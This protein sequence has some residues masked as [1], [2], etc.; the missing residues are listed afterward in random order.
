[1][2]V[3]PSNLVQG[4]AILWFAGFGTA[5]PA[6]SA[7]GSAPGGS[8]ADVGGTQG[9]V[10]WEVDDTY[11]DQ[12]V[13]QVAMPVGARFT[14]RAVTVTAK[15]AEATLSNMALALNSQVT[16]ASGSGYATLEPIE[17][18][19]A[20]QP[21]FTALIVD[22]WAPTLSSGG[23]ARRRLIVRKALSQPK[24]QL[25]YAMSGNGV[26]DVTWSGYYV[27]SSIK[28]FHVVDQTA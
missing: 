9:G 20:T 10:N 8:W 24:I 2:S 6:D 15:L 22:G 12:V 21:T 5:E 18:T 25:A 13:D 16:Q 28:A 14:K 27:S 17:G 3:T 1:M 23:A 19:S 26:Y 11:E 4:P 7:V